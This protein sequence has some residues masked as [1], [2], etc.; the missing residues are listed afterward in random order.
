MRPTGLAAFVAAMVFS[1][2][3]LAADFSVQGTFP[4][5]TRPG[6]GRLRRLSAETSDFLA[7]VAKR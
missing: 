4:T 2:S 7:I 1:A 3:T 6:R 5:W